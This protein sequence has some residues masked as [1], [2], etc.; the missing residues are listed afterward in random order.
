MP[1]NPAWDEE[2]LTVLASGRLRVVDAWTPEWFTQHGGHSAHE[3]RTWIAAYAALS[4]FGPYEVT[5]SF[6]API[7]EWMAGFGLTTARPTSS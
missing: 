2:A 6:Y 4:V 1:L 3:V 5:A 7:P